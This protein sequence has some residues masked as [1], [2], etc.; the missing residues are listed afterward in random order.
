[1]TWSLLMPL[2]QGPHTE[3]GLAATVAA[4]EAEVPVSTA[5]EAEVPV[6]PAGEAEAGGVSTLDPG[7]GVTAVSSLEGMLYFTSFW[8]TG[9]TSGGSSPWSPS[10]ACKMQVRPC[11]AE[12]EQTVIWRMSCVLTHSANVGCWAALGTRRRR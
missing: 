1:M 10:S 6:S 4:G 11:G 3:E 7:E 5:G 2:F 12:F 8:E 9:S